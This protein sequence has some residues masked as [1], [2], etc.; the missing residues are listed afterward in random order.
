MKDVEARNRR[1]DNA[2]HEHDGRLDDQIGFRRNTDRIGRVSQGL[3]D[4][5][6]EHGAH[7]TEASAEQRRAAERDGEDRIEFEQQAGVVAV[8][9]AHVGADQHT[10]QR[11]R[12]PG[13]HIDEKHDRP[14]AQPDKARGGRIDADG[15]DKQAQCSALHEGK[16]A[17]H[18]HHRDPYRKRHAEQVTAAKEQITGRRDR[19]DL[20]GREQLRNAASGDHQDQRGDDGLHADQRDQRAV[21]GAAEQADRERCEHGHKDGRTVRRDA[22]CEQRGG[23]GAGDGHD[24]TDRNVDAARGDHERHAE[25]YE[26]ERCGTVQDVDRGAEHVPVQDRDT[27]KAGMHDQIQRDQQNQG[28]GR[29]DQRALEPRAQAAR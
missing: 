28:Q 21:P 26:R 4:Q 9:A 29:P 1:L 20:P 3:D 16:G 24:G 6:A 22:R 8:G 18:D 15:P 19:D 12:E 23:H 27:Q 25:R 2:D 14:H 13:E 10:G 7:Q 5:C 11:R 17:E